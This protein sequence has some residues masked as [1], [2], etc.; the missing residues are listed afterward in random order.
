MKTRQS[1][2]IIKLTYNVSSLGNI[3]RVKNEEYLLQQEN[4]FAKLEFEMKL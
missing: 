1:L 4:I 3:K 2:S